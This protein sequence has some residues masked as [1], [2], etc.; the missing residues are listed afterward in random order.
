[1]IDVLQYNSVDGECSM[2]ISYQCWYNIIDM[3]ASYI[4]ASLHVTS[5]E[6]QSCNLTA[7]IL[8]PLACDF[9]IK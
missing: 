8:T 2:V 9:L 7:T 3:V 1:M 6:S 5:Q 4:S